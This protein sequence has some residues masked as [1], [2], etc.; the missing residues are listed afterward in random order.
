MEQEDVLD[1]RVPNV[2][3]VL[4]PPPALGSREHLVGKEGEPEALDEDDAHHEEGN[5]VA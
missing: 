5:G 1:D 2:G 4:L 3:A